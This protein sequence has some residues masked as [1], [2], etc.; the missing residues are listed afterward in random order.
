MLGKLSVA[1]C[2]LL[3]LDGSMVSNWDTLDHEA[4]TAKSVTAVVQGISPLLQMVG[5]QNG[6]G[7]LLVESWPRGL[8]SIA[9]DIAAQLCQLACSFGRNN[10]PAIVW[11][12]DGPSPPAFT[13]ELAGARL[14]PVVLSTPVVHAGARLVLLTRVGGDLKILQDRLAA[15]KLQTADHL[16]LLSVRSEWQQPSSEVFASSSL[17]TGKGQHGV[18][19]A[20]IL[21]GRTG[22]SFRDSMS[23]L[24]WGPLATGQDEIEAPGSYVFLLLP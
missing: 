1:H 14:M 2:Q 11:A 3:T 8:Q 19:M 5:L 16:L 15:Q 9:L 6:D 12:W 21:K 20:E 4:R 24:S 7:T 22:L 10:Q 17:A 13:L 18:E 23:A